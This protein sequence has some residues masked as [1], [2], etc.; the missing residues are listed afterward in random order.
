MTLDYIKLVVSRRVNGCLDV[1]VNSFLEIQTCE[2]LDIISNTIYC[3]LASCTGK[4]IILVV[5]NTDLLKCPKLKILKWPG[6]NQY[7]DLPCIV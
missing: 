3:S 2:L 5:Q 4:V 7:Y 6:P 1:F